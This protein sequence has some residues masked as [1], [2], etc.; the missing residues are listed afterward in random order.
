MKKSLQL[1]RPKELCEL[2]NISIPTLYR[3]E[4]EGRLP[5]PKIKFGPN[6]VGFRMSDVENW[7]NGDLDD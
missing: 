3:W 5:I 1:I 6:C 4:A 7:I 2:L